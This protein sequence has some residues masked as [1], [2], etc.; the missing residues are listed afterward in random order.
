[1][2]TYRYPSFC[3]FLLE[4]YFIWDAVALTLNQ[5]RNHVVSSSLVMGRCAQIAGGQSS[6]VQCVCEGPNPPELQSTRASTSP[7]P[8]VLRWQ[9]KAAFCEGRGYLKRG[10][11]QARGLVETQCSLQK[12]RQSTPRVET[13][14]GA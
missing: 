13:R 11:C 6:P 7:A 9:I 2:I 1:M 10:K 4:N 8:R 14:A 12:E 3:L 5:S